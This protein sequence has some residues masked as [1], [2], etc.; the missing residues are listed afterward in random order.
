MSLCKAGLEM[1]TWGKNATKLDK[2]A[3]AQT[4]DIYYV[5]C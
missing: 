1:G 5:C 4:N 3:P 2:N